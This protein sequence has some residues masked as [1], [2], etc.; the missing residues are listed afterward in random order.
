MFFSHDRLLS[1]P[2][3][4]LDLVLNV[5]NSVRG[6]DL[7]CDGLASQG[8]NEDLHATTETQH[9]VEGGL[10]LDVVVGE[11]AT[12]LELLTS[13]DKALLVG[14]DAARSVS[15]ASLE[16]IYTLDTHP[17]LSWILF[18]TLSMVSDDSTSRVIVLPV[19]VLTKIC[20]I[21][22]DKARSGRSLQRYQWVDNVH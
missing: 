22:K 15:I 3:L 8:L 17:S 11:R 6:L 16:S 19:S 5:I 2:F 21:L 14:R 12:V 13:E 4:V 10:L 9:Q 20:M 7:E 18:L 1:L